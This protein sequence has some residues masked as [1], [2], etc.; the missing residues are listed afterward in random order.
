MSGRRHLAD[1]GFMLSPGPILRIAVIRFSSLGDVLCTGP[2]VRGLHRTFPEAEI[3][4]IT[5]P[6]YR[7]LAAALPGVTRVAV[8]ERRGGKFAQD[9]DR[10]VWEGPWDRVADLQGSQKSRRLAREMKPVQSVTDTPPRIRRGLLQTTRIKLGSFPSVPERMLGRMKK[11]GVEDDGASLRVDIPVSARGRVDDRYGDKL[12]GAIALVPGAKHRTKRWPE[13]HWAELVRSLP[14]EEMIVVVGAE[15][16]MPKQMDAALKGRAKRGMDLTGET[17]PM[18]LASIL[19][20]AS[21]VISGDTGPMHLAVAVQTPVV[22]MFGP[23][24]REFGFYPFRARA[25]VLEQDIW[26][27]PCS[28]HGGPRCPLGHH[29][30]LEEITPEEVVM[31]MERVRTTGDKDQ[32][33]E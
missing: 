15:G 20:R 3:V 7:D 31:A 1:A 19:N 12:N 4:F 25:E 32:V 28:A 23:T 30:C 16:E 13:R 9:K 26:C 10:V 14:P 24:V 2:A 22:A 6:H 8:V 29:R 17:T 11:W 33:R 5:N 21:V 27:R 18:E